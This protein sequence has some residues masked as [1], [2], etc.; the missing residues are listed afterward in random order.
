[1]N[2][3][4]ITCDEYGFSIHEIVLIKKDDDDNNNNNNDNIKRVR[5]C[6][7]LLKAIK[8]LS[9][10]IKQSLLPCEKKDSAA[11]VKYGGMIINNR[12]SR[13]RVKNRP[14]AIFP[15]P[16]KLYKFINLV[17]FQLQIKDRRC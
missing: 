8:V 7:R 1:M 14:Y 15:E 16:S 3:L 17:T 9:G 6:K 10:T 12:K 13:R 2:Q 11:M 4:H 5:K